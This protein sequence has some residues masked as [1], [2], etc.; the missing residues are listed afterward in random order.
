[1]YFYLLINF[2]DLAYDTTESKSSDIK[3]VKNSIM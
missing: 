3:Q 2:S 1:M